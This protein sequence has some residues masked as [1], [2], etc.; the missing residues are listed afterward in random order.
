[1]ETAGTVIKCRAAVTWC[2]NEPFSIEVVE[3]APPKAHEI[4][5]KMVYTGICGSD[6]NAV[7][8]K[9]KDMQFPIILGH[10]G[11]GIV[12][13]IGGGVKGFKPGDKVI[14][15]FAPQCGQCRCCKDPRTN[16]CTTARMERP[17][18]LMADGTS[19][20]TCKGKKIYNFLNTSTFTE[21]TVIDEIAAVKIDENTALDNIS[22]IGCGFSTGYGSA[23]NAAKVHPGS[24]CA[25]FGLGGVGL[26]AVMGCKAAGASRI[27]GVDINKGKFGLAKELGATEC[28]NPKDY[29]KPIQQVLVEQTGGGLDYVFECIGD[30]ETMVAAINSSHHGFGTTVIVGVS[31]ANKTITFDPMIFLTGRTLT[32]SV[33]GGWKPK[34]S[35]PKLVHDYMEKKFDLDK[36]VTHRLPFEKINEGFDYLRKGKS[37][38]TILRF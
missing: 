7:Y 28:I 22:L 34:D 31:A 17:K 14:P 20:F 32:G 3:V 27:I 11:V 9:F 1:M 18:G 36:L 26:A 2:V 13:S 29:D 37:I 16:I 12:E 15:L 5:I 6:D 10:E 23:L 25:V 24:S 33:F 21:Y 38:R 8:G 4:R 19:R 30:T 35:V